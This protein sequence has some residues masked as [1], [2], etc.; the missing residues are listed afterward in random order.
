MYVRDISICK[1]H[2][3]TLY[4]QCNVENRQGKYAVIQC[5]CKSHYRKTHN[6][7]CIKPRIEMTDLELKQQDV[8]DSLT[9]DQFAKLVQA[10]DIK[11]FDL[12]SKVQKSA[13]LAQIPVLID[14]CILE[15]QIK[16]EAIHND[17]KCEKVGIFV[18]LI[19]IFR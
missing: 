7:D 10:K 3:K 5:C 14:N 15:W 13:F 17:C 6:N 4:V 11:R 8:I 16:Q 19:A 2:Y 9:D 1:G 12:L 18:F